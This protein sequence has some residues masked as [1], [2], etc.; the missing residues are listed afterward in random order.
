MAIWNNPTVSG[1]EHRAKDWLSGFKAFILRGNVVDLA[2]GII[3]GVAFTGVV[4]GLVNDII[5]PLIPLPTG[6]LADLTWKPPY[7]STPVKFGAFIN[8]IITFLIIAIVIYFFIV[9]PVNTL[10]AHYKPKEAAP[11]ATGE[12]P[13]CLSTIPLMATRCAYCTSPLPP[14]NQPNQAQPAPQQ[15]A[16]QRT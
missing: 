11:P 8:A 14:A 15:E 7:S 1:A 10:M 12:C 3:I 9:R 13:Y 2:V 16:A 5:T 4:N 6:S